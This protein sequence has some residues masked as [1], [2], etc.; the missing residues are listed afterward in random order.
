[1]AAPDDQ[2]DLHAITELFDEN[3]RTMA[4]LPSLTEQLCAAIKVV[5]DSLRDGGKL[6]VCG[7]GGSAADAQHMAAEFVCRFARDRRPFAAVALTTDSSV[8][9]A[10]ANDY[11]YDEVFSRQVRALGRAGDVLVAISTSGSSSNVVLAAERARESGIHVIGLMGAAPGSLAPLCD[12]AL[13]VPS[14]KTP[15]IQEGHVV[16]IHILCELVEAR[17]C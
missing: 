12:V 5:T 8:L 4:A 1:M 16:L 11:S 14:T 10:T 7:N 15:R 13:R 9:T 2:G 3:Q 6:L 17:L